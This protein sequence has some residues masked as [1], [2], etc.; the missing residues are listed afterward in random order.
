VSDVLLIRQQASNALSALQEKLVQVCHCTCAVLACALM[1]SKVHAELEKLRVRNREETARARADARSA[2]EQR[3][4]DATNESL[5]DSSAL[6]SFIESSVAGRFLFA[7]QKY[8][9]SLFTH[10]LL[11]QKLFRWSNPLFTCNRACSLTDDS[12]NSW[13]ARKGKRVSDGREK[14]R[15]PEAP[16][17]LSRHSEATLCAESAA[18]YRTVR[19]S[20]VLVGKALTQQ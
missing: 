15:K 16:P 20:V 13:K 12:S 3:I 10:N 7:F 8:G 17:P 19:G 9:G 11:L 4:Q 2:Y 14:F 1:R 18:G 5:A 6:A